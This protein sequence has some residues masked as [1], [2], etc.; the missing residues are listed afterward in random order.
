M[1]IVSKITPLEECPM[2]GEE[3]VQLTNSCPIENPDHKICRDCV[4]N[5][6]NKYNKNFC[7]YCGERPII[8]NIPIAVQPEHDSVNI[9]IQTDNSHWLND[10]F[11]IWKKNNQIILNLIGGI[12]SYIGL[13]YNWHL[14]RM[15]N[16]YMEEGELMDK[17]VDWHIYNALYALFIDCC[18]AIFLAHICE[19][20]C[21][22]RSLCR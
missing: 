2:C 21:E 12:L 10:R 7:A 22:N 3:G 20:R 15:I 16:H 6:K 19:N 17:E 18:L 14:Y 13:I 11:Q 5:L 1:A 8:I 4:D 9:T